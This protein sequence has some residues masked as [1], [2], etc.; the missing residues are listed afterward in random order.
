MKTLSMLVVLA[1]AFTAVVMAAPEASASCVESGGPVVSGTACSSG[2]C[3]FVIL[4]G[5]E[6]FDC[7]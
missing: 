7:P 2:Y 3:H 1:I 5:V 6:H 4:G